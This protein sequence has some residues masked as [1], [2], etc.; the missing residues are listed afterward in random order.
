MQHPVHRHHRKRARGCNAR[1][2]ATC[3]KKNANCVSTGIR[4]H[5]V[6]HRGES[7]HYDSSAASSRTVF[8]RADYRLTEHLAD[9]GLERVSLRRAGKEASAVAHGAA[10]TA[11]EVRVFGR[12]EV[13]QIVNGV[14]RHIVV[15]HEDLRSKAESIPTLLI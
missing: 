12:V 7:S 2:N 13:M 14:E 5:D 10:L 3:R 4:T 6:F 9:V 8:A 1:S 11:E 15:R